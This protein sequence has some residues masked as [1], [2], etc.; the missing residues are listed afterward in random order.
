MEE[1]SELVERVTKGGVLPQLTSCCPGW[2]KFV[3]YYYPELIPN[4]S[5]ARS[6]MM[7]HGPTLKT[8]NAEKLGFHYK[9]VVNVA[10]MPCLAKKFEIS[11][12]MCGQAPGRRLFRFGAAFAQPGKAFSQAPVLCRTVR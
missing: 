2:V 7:M 8:Y 1:G 3:E 4:L 6:P 11:R 10:I 12:Q 9:N 5:S